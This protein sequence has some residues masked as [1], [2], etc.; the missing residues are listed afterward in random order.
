VFRWLASL[1]VSLSEVGLSAMVAE[2][3]PGTAVHGVRPVNGGLA[4]ATFAVDTTVGDLIVKVYPPGNE[5]VQWEWDG[6]SF[7]QRV[8]GAPRPEP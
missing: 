3:A 1:F 6:L 8:V 2:I 7:A 4:A 5:R